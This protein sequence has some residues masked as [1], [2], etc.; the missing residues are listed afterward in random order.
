MN[1]NTDVKHTHTNGEYNINVDKFIEAYKDNKLEYIPYYTYLPD[2]IEIVNG[3]SVCD[4]V[5]GKG[6]FML[7]VLVKDQYGNRISLRSD[8]FEPIEDKK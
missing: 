6:A 4:T 7:H 8:N 2:G 5:R 1:T 3:N